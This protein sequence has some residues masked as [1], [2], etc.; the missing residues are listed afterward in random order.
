VFEETN[1]A[2]EIIQEEFERLVRVRTAVD[3]TQRLMHK[4]LQDDVCLLVLGDRVVVLNCGL[5]T[6]L[7]ATVSRS[8]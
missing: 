5:E 8:R 2:Q 3:F 1:V 6:L 7:Q 4:R